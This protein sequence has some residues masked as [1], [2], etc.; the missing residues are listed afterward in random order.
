MKTEAWV[1]V[2]ANRLQPVAPGAAG[3]RL[4]LA[5][6]AGALLAVLAVVWGLGVRP[7]FL[8]ALQRPEMWLKLGFPLAVSLVSAVVVVRI[9]VPGRAP[10]VLRWAWCLL[11]AAMGLLGATALWLADPA[12]R[13]ALWMGTTWGSCT[14]LIVALSTPVLGSFLL[15]LRSLAPTQLRLSGGMAGVLA[16]A[17]GT[18]AY[19][20]H[21]PEMA[22]PFLALWNTLAILLMGLLG[23][24][25][26]P[27]TLRW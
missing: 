26:G 25:L 14:P 3:R 1:N 5:L 17:V 19:A 18:L 10:G 12:D 9:S 11:A 24:L 8:P 6:I 22:L 21:C 27:R 13:N 23:V 16:G 2:L 7:D 4:L 15:A 20:L